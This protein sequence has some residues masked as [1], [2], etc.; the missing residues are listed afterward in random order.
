MSATPAGFERCVIVVEDAL[1][2][3]LAANAAA[4]L[5]VTLGA[6]APELVGPPLTDADGHEHP[7]LIGRGL[8]ILRGDRA[9]LSEL[10]RT[11]T[12]LDAGLIALPTFGQQTT[13]YDAFR[14]EVART[15]AAELAYL[16]LL[17]HGPK[18]TI[19]KLTGH[20]PLLR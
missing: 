17:V 7:G 16:G 12:E 3:G 13:D 20:L 6:M 1:P 10:A 15:S 4:V 19:N 18:R 5:A 11:A 2:R 14:G 8:P 9:Q